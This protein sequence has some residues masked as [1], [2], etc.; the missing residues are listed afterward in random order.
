MK[1]WTFDGVADPAIL[2]ARVTGTL[3]VARAATAPAGG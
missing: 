3:M 2:V 1:L